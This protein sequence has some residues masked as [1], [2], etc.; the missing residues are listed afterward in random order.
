MF[1]QFIEADVHQLD[2][3]DRVLAVPGIDRAV[4]GL[5]VKG[6]HRA[7]RRIVLHAVAGREPFADVQVDDRVDVLEIAGAHEERAACD[8][9]LRR[10]VRNRD[11]ARQVVALHHLLDR[12]RGERGDAAVRVVSLHVARAVLDQRLALPGSRRL[13]AA[14]QGID[15]GDDRD[16]WPAIAVLGPDI[17]GHA[18]AAQLDLEAGGGKRVFEELGA[19]E[20]L[21]AEL[22][23]IEQRVAHIGHLLRVALDHVERE[24]L[25]L[26]RRRCGAC[27]DK[28]KNNCNARN[29]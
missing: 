11:R 22:A 4:R 12:E 17:G 10:P 23:E 15:L 26:V 8:L 24:L 3:V 20:L 7:D 19:L 21:H 9:L 6:E 27:T 5:A 13:R 14:G 18:G 2:R 1:A 25:A 16:L 28:S 29:P